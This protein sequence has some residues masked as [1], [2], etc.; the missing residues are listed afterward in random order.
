MLGLKA[1]PPSESTAATESNFEAEKVEQKPAEDFS[2]KLAGTDADK[3][4]EKRAARAKRFGMPID[5]EEQKKLERA[6]KFGEALKANVQGLDSA[7]P[8]RRE[9]QKRGR[10]EQ[11]GRGNAKRPTPDRRATG[12][13]RNGRNNEA[14][15]PTA[16]G[17]IKDDPTEKA[18]AEARALKF[19]TSV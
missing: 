9:R 5:A 16:L 15:K 12:S 1:S 19:K 7:L 14:K 3:E 13:V 18:K 11:G 2:A 8:E 10:E 6:K 4:A 17:K